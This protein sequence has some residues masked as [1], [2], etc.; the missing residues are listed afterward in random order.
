MTK[1]LL[2]CCALLLA[3]STTLGAQSLAERL[4]RR[5]DGP[6]L[7]RLLWGVAVTDLDGHLLFGRNA[8]RLFIPASN[9]KLVVSITANML[10]G[11]GFSVR[12]SVYGSGPVANGVLQGDVVL[13]GRGDPTF[14]NR[15]YDADTTKPGVCDHDPAAKLRQLAEQLRDRGVRVIAGDIIG[16]G[17][18]FTPQI[19]HPGWEVYDLG[20]WYAAPVSGLGFNDNAV[21]V[22]E[23]AGDSAGTIPD[24][25]MTPD[26]GAFALDNRA[27]TGARGARRSFDIFRSSDG[28]TYLATGIL[29]AGSAPRNESAAVADPNRY[30]AL[31]FRHELLAA[32]ILVRGETRSTV[33]SFTYRSI[34]STAPLAEAGSRPFKDWLYPILS[35]SQNWFA[36]MTLKQLGRQFGTAGSWEEGR[37]VERRFLI[38]S[39]GIDSTEFSLQ[40]GS[41]LASNNFVTPLA[42]TKLLTYARKHANFAAI[43]GGLPQSG[44]PGTLRDRFAGTPAATAV[45]AKTGSISGVNTLSGFV[46]RADGK[47][48]VFSVMANHHTLGSARMIAAIDS[49]VVELAKPEK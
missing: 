42:F 14:S 27:E 24:L 25:I 37:R 35:S 29:P 21:D 43:N 33:D 13:Y 23:I 17:S 46:E 12:T 22:R 18:Y 38:D 28:L 30:A 44:K 40:D 31:A 3:A 4:D 26:L 5:L 11:P 10:L 6:G 48:L 45:H 16:D 32:G 20:W 19:I 7:D 36:E 15:C 1:S 9:T 8:D 49:V 2:S 39:V 41:G 47:V 34:R